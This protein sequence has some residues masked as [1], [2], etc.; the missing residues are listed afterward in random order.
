MMTSKPV[1]QFHKN[2]VKKHIDELLKKNETT[3]D[4]PFLRKLIYEELKSKSLKFK[5]TIVGYG[6]VIPLSG[7][8]SRFD[9]EANPK[10]I[11]YFLT[12][13]Y[14][15][16]DV[17]YEDWHSTTPT[18]IEELSKLFDRNV[19]KDEK[20]K[21]LVRFQ[22]DELGGKFKSHIFDHPRKPIKKITLV[23]E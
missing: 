13:G 2:I 3:C 12:R 22:N 4:S 17:I 18:N 19:S 6:K 7:D 1:H 9:Y 16:K 11:M 21:I 15:S 10:R 5:S 23:N 14:Y 20:F 8:P